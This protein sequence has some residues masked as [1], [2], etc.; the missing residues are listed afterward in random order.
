MLLRYFVMTSFF[1]NKCYY[2][3]SCLIWVR[4][5][6]VMVCV[7]REHAW[8][9][10]EGRTPET[11][12]G[13]KFIASNPR[14]VHVARQVHAPCVEMGVNRGYSTTYVRDPEFPYIDNLN[15]SKTKQYSE[16]LKTSLRFI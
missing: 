2:V 3:T 4:D 16:K 15:I 5:N 10:G 1:K 11:Y 12:G 7:G 9:R 14:G 6:D 8:S 13:S